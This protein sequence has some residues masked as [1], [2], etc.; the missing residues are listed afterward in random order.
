MIWLPG[1][2][3]CT[4]YTLIVGSVLICSDQHNTINENTRIEMHTFIR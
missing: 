2:I 1:V 4:V 3:V